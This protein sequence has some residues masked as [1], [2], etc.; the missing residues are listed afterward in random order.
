MEH[1]NGTKNTVAGGRRINVRIPL[2]IQFPT[3]GS[4]LAER[5]VHES[6]H[7]GI[8]FIFQK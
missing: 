2:N 8:S 6:I 4:G 7:K 5:Q 1:S 3:H